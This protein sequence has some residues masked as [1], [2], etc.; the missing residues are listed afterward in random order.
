MTD[1]VG[2]TVDRKR[3]YQVK[4]PTW[5]DMLIAYSTLPGYVA[6]RDHYR[7]T[8]FIESLCQVN[9]MI[10][11]YH[12]LVTDLIRYSWTMPPTPTSVRCST[13]WRAD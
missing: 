12:R 9:I 5:E 1:A 3:S 13:T 10:H 6:N 4:D 2:V 7:G 11:S 8:W